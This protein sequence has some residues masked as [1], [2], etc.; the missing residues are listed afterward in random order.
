VG[1]LFNGNSGWS[2]AGYGTGA[3]TDK[4]LNRNIRASHVLS[5]GSRIYDFSGNV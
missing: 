4:G 1:Y 5:N 2:S 3:Q